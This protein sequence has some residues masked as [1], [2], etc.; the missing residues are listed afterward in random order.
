MKD[1]P[2]LILVF[3][4]FIAI[5][6]VFS[7][8]LRGDYGELRLNPEV[9]DT[10]DHFL[11]NDH[12]NYYVSGPDACPNA[13]M[14]IDK[15]WVLASDLWRRTELTPATMKELVGQMRDKHLPLHGFDIID[16]RK[17]KIG[18]WYSVL[19]IHITIKIAGENRI[20]VSTP[21][22]NVNI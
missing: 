10:F 16:H 7:R 13:I 1:I 9:A 17:T 4:L 5:A 19:D 2:T 18:A 20:V 22:L 8:Y 3:L 11:I 6:F 21:A 15:T 12:F 14:G